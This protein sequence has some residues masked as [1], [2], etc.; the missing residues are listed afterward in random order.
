MG[1]WKRLVNKKMLIMIVVV[2]VANMFL[3]GYGQLKGKSIDRIESECEQRQWLINY[4]QKMPL[5]EA[6]NH[7]ASVNKVIR[8]KQLDNQSENKQKIDEI[9]NEIVKSDKG[10]K[11]DIAVDISQLETVLNYYEN[12]SG[13]QQAEFEQVISEVKNKLGY[14][15]GYN[16]DVSQIIG[17]ADR[18]KKFSVFS[19][20]ESFSYR[21]IIQT[22]N[23]F[24]RVENLEPV[25]CNDEAVRQFLAYPQMFYLALALMVLI[26]Y[27]IFQER[28]NGVWVMV[29]GVPRGRISLAVKRTI[30]LALSS[31]G[32]MAVLYISVLIESVFI[33]GGIQS[34]TAPIQ[35]LPQFADFTYIINQGTY[36]LLLFLAEWFVIFSLSCFFWM[37]FVIFRN[38]NH[39][40][41]VAGIFVGLEALLYEKISIQSVYGNFKR[42]NIMRF[43]NINEVLRTYEN[44]NMLGMVISVW[45][46]M[47]LI[48]LILTFV[49]ILV[50][51]KCTAGKYPNGNV[52][53][54]SA[55]I[56][57]I[58]RLYQKIFERTPLLLKELHKLVVTSKGVWIIATVIILTMYFA[59]TG[60]MNFTMGMKEKDEI[61]LEHGGTD[62]S[63]ITELIKGIEQEC[64]EAQV[65]L[66]EVAA[67]YNSGNASLEA[68]VNASTQTIQCGTKL[69]TVE[70]FKNKFEYLDNIEAEYGVE[71]Y[72]MSDRGY[73]EIFGQYSTQRELIL[74]LIMVAGIM[75]IVSECITMEY[76]TGMEYMLRTAKKG[77]RWLT[78]RKLIACII[79]TMI[80]FLLVY[81]IDYIKMYQFYGLPYLDAPLMSLT[82]MEGVSVKYTVGGWIVMRLLARFIVGLFAMAAAFI[83]SRIVGR[84]GNRGL[85]FLSTVIVLI[86]VILV[87]SFGW[88]L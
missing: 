58:Y 8:R 43:L 25:L 24:K 13:V 53:P 54:F 76:H 84:K 22:G 39:A 21:N 57:R 23:D 64:E 79:L 27:N 7:I 80:V 3:F 20:T 36:L 63:Y 11:E 56:D 2:M 18:L 49:S 45:K 29:H 26:I 47:L 42:I 65:R 67:E 60:R 50:A 40:L 30:I 10:E 68:L 6:Y 15:S 5:E 31:I 71:G 83:T 66:E 82:F 9:H 78:I 61:Y 1:E 41:I 44:A 69:K 17:N 38:R 52:S 51:V 55:V 37:L 48:M 87:N 12:L 28:E 32:I 59:G 73:E 77:R 81:G 35:S 86:L 19:D 14:L 70:E 75:L 88:L 4:Y 62:R 74:L 34:F 16:E 85:S 72:L 46:F 33:Y